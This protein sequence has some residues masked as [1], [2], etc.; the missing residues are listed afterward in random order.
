MTIA[1][2]PEWQETTLLD[3]SGFAIGIRHELLQRGK[4]PIV[5]SKLGPR[6]A[7][8][9][10]I[11]QSSQDMVPQD[12]LHFCPELLTKPAPIAIIFGVNEQRCDQI[13]VFNIQPAAWPDQ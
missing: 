9:W 3:A 11:E 13:D 2:H 6:L 10:H 12:H 1:P 4:E 7:N 8:P 5:V